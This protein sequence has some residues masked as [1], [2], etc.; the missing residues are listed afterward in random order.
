[1]KLDAVVY[2][3][4]EG[5]FAACLQHWIFCQADSHAKIYGELERVIQAHVRLARVRGKEPFSSLP[6]A[7]KRFWDSFQH[8]EATKGP[9]LMI[10][11]PRELGV[12]EPQLTIRERAA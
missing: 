5:W 10:Q 11:I 2:R 7:P 6:Q 8:P 3:T 4:E 9:T 1:M 12:P